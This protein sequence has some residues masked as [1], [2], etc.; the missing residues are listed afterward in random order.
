MFNWCLSLQT[1]QKP[2]QLGEKTPCS[3]GGKMFCQIN[4]KELQ[5]RQLVKVVMRK[6]EKGSRLLKDFHF[7]ST[8]LS[9]IIVDTCGL[10]S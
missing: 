4:M 10:Y 8:S 9:M 2:I 1:R 7:W 3:S 6:R 5:E